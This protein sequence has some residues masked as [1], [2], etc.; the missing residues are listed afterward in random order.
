MKRAPGQHA[1]RSVVTDGSRAG[2]RSCSS[3]R[4]L[5][6]ARDFV[7]GRRGLF[8]GKVGRLPREASA[9]APRV[10]A[11]ARAASRRRRRRGAARRCYA[12]R[13]H[14][15][16]PGHR[17]DRPDAGPSVETRRRS[18]DS[19]RPGR[20]PAAGRRARAS[21]ALL[22][23][24]ARRFG[25]IHRPEADADGAGAR[26]G[27]LRRGVRPAGRPRAAAGAGRGLTAMPGPPRAGGLRDG[28]RRAAA[29]RADRR[30][31]RGRRGRRA[32]SSPATHPMQRL[33]QGE[34]GLGQDGGG[35]AGDA[36]GRRRR[37]AGGAARARPRSWPSSTTGRSPSC[38]ARWP[39]AG[40]LGGSD[41]GTRVA[42]LTG[43]QGHRR[44]G[45]AARRGVRRRRHRHRARTR[46][47]RTRC[48][49]STSAW[50]SS[51]SSTGSVSSSGRRLAA[52]RARR[53]RPHVL[54]MTATPIP[55]TVAMTVFGD[56]ETSTLTELP[57][58]RAPI[59][60]HVVPAEQRRLRRAR[61]GADPRGGGR[62]P[63]GLRRLPADRRRP[64]SRA[65][66]RAG[67]RRPWPRTGRAHA[68][69]VAVLDVAAELA[70]GPLAGLRVEILHGQLAPDEKDDVMRRFAP[71]AAADIDVLVATTVVEVGVDVPNATVMV[72]MDA[73]RFGVSPAAPAARPGR[74]GAHRALCLL[75]TDVPDGSPARER[76]DAVAA[77]ARRLRALAARPR[78]APRGR[79]ARAPPSPAAGR[80]CDCC[81]CCATTTSSPPRGSRPPT[82]CAPTPPSRRGPALRRAVESVLTDDQADF[83]ERS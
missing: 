20:R 22:G 50:W 13:A 39:S 80:R 47:S 79:R 17:K 32:R 73:D 74:A 21:H 57:A 71:S 15:R 53:S 14:P 69:R 60:T 35:A 75:V 12:D 48:S 9:R 23:P 67:A 52:E 31:A 26:T 7:E 5:P 2:S 4:Q 19:P 82:S 33:L 62:R 43:S 34:V 41:I 11:A 44:G 37:R 8:D 65:G 55:R 49:S 72:V 78:A 63:A 24:G 61:L 76:L 68:R 59:A 38:S 64:R 28:L 25:C 77:H 58:G 36:H 70:D 56:L 29:V 10:P 54:V 3:T 30:A 40:M 51:T 42:L 1:R 45:G 66:R 27:S 81:R 16:L 83:L 6:R 18:L 46:C